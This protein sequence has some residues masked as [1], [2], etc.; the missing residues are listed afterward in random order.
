M[1]EGRGKCYMTYSFRDK[2]PSACE[3]LPERDTRDECY[4]AYYAS[5]ENKQFCDL[6]KNPEKYCNKKVPEVIFR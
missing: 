2:D 4:W 5:T 3:R 1:S 6:M